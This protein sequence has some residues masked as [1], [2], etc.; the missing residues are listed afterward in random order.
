MDHLAM[1][2]IGP[3]PTTPDGYNYVLVLVDVFSRFVFLRALV[4]KS[5]AS[6]AL[7]LLLIIAD[8]GPPK[9]I[10]SDNGTEF[11]NDVVKGMLALLR[12]DQR[13]TSPYH[14]RANGLAERFV[15][16]VTK[17]LLKLPQGEIV[18]WKE[19]LPATQL[20][21]NAKISVL[22]GAT[23]FSAMFTRSLTAFE[24]FTVSPEILPVLVEK[25]MAAAADILFP[26]LRERTQ[27][28]LKQRKAR[29]DQSHQLLTPLQEGT[30]IGDDEKHF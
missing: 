24:D 14:P 23:P 3:M 29:F 1:D 8:F 12:V 17:T 20:M 18:A 15:Q 10:Q 19:L 4:D 21:L 5:A 13:C 27:V 16:T 9:I 6:V 11:V 7:A 25:R 28:V 22:H 2:L 30:C 26:N